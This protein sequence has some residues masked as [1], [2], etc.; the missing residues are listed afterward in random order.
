M[1]QECNRGM[2]PCQ[3][4]PPKKSLLPWY[5]IHV[6]SNF[7]QTVYRALEY[8]GYDLFLPTYRVRRRWS[9]RMKDTDLPLFPGYLFCRLDLKNRLPV[10]T[11]PGVL[12][13][14]GGKNP[15][16][17]NEHEMAFVQTVLQSSLPY[18]PWDALAPGNRVVV[19]HG[20]LMGIQGT[21]LELRDRNR[22]VVS[23]KILNRAL[24]VEID[25]AWVRPS[26]V[27]VQ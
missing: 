7:E 18:L 14:V 9:D 15:A 10:L 5:A 16:P 23:I 11:T 6:R 24:A 13:L 26:G 3:T 21:L 17:V 20:P 19:D 22:L 2:E 1:L 4:P 8:K 12:Q 27:S 25:A